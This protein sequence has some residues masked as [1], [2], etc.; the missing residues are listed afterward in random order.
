MG[1]IR[2]V[3]PS[4]NQTH[5]FFRIF[6]DKH[7]PLNVHFFRLAIWFGVECYQT[8]CSILG[9]NQLRVSNIPY[10]ALS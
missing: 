1:K 3:D 9:R 8:Y 4:A 2:K 7:L 10:V 5:D 6:S